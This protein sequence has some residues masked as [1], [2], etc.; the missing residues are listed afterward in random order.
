M[1]DFFVP[2]FLGFL[3]GVMVTV[4]VCAN[5]GSTSKPPY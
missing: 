1:M 5:Y 2:L 4:I 3:L